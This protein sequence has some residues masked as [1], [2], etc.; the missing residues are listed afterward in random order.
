[1]SINFSTKYFLYLH[2]HKNLAPRTIS[3]S[4]LL[5][6][7]KIHTEDVYTKFVFYIFF[8]DLNEN[9]ECPKEFRLLLN[10][11]NLLECIKDNLFETKTYTA[12]LKNLPVFIEPLN[13]FNLQMK[14]REIFYLFKFLLTLELKIHQI[15][16]EVPDLINELVYNMDRNTRCD[17]LYLNFKVSPLICILLQSMD[18]VDVLNRYVDLWYFLISLRKNYKEGFE[19]ISS[20]NINLEILE[21]DI[22]YSKYKIINE[23]HRYLVSYFPEI[24]YVSKT[25]PDRLIYFK[26]P[27]EIPIKYKILKKYIHCVPYYYKLLNTKLNDVSFDILFRLIYIE[28]IFKVG[29]NKKWTKLIHILILDNSNILYVLLRRQF[30]KKNIR[31]LVKY[32]PSFHLSFDLSL[33]FYKESK[34]DFYLEILKYLLIKYPVKDYFYKIL[35]NIDIFPKIFIIRFQDIFDELEGVT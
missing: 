12:D 28:R 7:N 31:I 18:S 14:Q 22:L 27:L 19:F 15:Y 8:R 3:K 23:Y 13:N 5:I 20:C 34:A 11:P 16:L 26:N 24:I 9:L 32:V 2:R 33:R 21:K 17:I 6:Y 29:L 10:Y 30:D 1:M 25:Y 4:V 35:A